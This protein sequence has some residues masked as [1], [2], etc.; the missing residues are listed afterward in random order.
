MATVELEEPLG[1]LG[2]S[3]Q[4]RDPTVA[5]RLLPPDVDP[6]LEFMVSLMIRVLLIEVSAYRAFEWAQDWLSD[7]DLVAGDGMAGR[8]VGYIRSD[9][10]PH[11]A[12]LQ[13]ALSEL[14]ARTWVGQTDAMQP[15]AE[16][17]GTPWT[18]LLKKSTGIG[19]QR[20]REAVD[21]E[22]ERW[23]SKKKNGAEI[24]AHFHSLAY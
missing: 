13:T 1:R 14:T 18:T 19:R 15:G 10:S 11:V 5:E 12:S 2:L 23:C 20:A 3:C 16:L 21:A 24:L 7:S 4:A 8:I 9:E 6:E 22:V 17:V